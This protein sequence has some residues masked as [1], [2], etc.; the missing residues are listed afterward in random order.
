MRSCGSFF[1]VFL[2]CTLLVLGGAGG[3]VLFFQT[4]FL[5][6][7]G[8][9]GT[10]SLDQAGI[11]LR[12]TCLCLPNAGIKG[13]SHHAWLIFVYTDSFL[14]FFLLLINAKYL[15]QLK[16]ENFFPLP[17]SLSWQR[18]HQVQEFLSLYTQK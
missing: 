2:S 17:H 11:Q 10:S 18:S 5:C 12:S 15:K 7:P 1:D 14:Y 3:A 9:P 16:G 4:S 6:S 8:S 13:V